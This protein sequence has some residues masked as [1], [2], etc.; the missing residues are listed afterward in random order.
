M[1]NNEEVFVGKSLK[2]NRTE[3]DIYC[4][5]LELGF[6]TL[7]ETG[8]SSSKFKIQFLFKSCNISFFKR[9]F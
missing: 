8:K 4:Y 9:I 7:R 3:D 1:S 2:E 6:G 5:I